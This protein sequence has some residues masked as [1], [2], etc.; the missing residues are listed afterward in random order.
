MRPIAINLHAKR[1]METEAYIGKARE[2]GFNALMS[3][4][5][6]LE[7]LEKIAKLLL[8]QGMSYEM[9]HA[10]FRHVNDIWRDDESGERMLAEM[11]RALPRWGAPPLSC[12]S[13]RGR[14]YL[15]SPI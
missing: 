9:I 5:L 7:E 3:E 4:A 10:P 14:S 13:R 15:G 1:G 2:V 6:P 12:I 11:F 8:Q